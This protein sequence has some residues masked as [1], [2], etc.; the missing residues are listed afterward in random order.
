[1]TY[2]RK[3]PAAAITPIKAVRRKSRSLKFIQEGDSN[4]FRY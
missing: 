3:K 4:R 1:M 2:I